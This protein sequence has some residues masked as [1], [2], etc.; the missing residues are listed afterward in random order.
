MV[1]VATGTTPAAEGA[2]VATQSARAV[3]IVVV[4]VVGTT[5]HDSWGPNKVAAGIVADMTG[6]GSR[7]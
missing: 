3:R 5:P 1:P 7:S 4:E 6:P 2:A